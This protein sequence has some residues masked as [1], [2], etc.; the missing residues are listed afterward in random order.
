DKI[1]K[2]DADAIKDE[3]ER[4]QSTY[5][6]EL[7]NLKA[8]HIKELDA[9]ETY[10]QAMGILRQT[11]TEEELKDIKTL[12]DAR[13][14]I[15][16][17]QQ[18]KEAEL[19]MQHID[20]LI[21]LLNTFI[22]EGKM[23]N[24]SFLD[25]IISTEE[26]E[27]AKKILNELIE[28]LQQLKKERREATGDTSE[29][30][31]PG[32]KLRGSFRTDILGFTTEDWEILFSA[33]DKTGD[34]LEEL[35]DRV[36]M[37]AYAIANAWSQANQIAKNSEDKALAEYEKRIDYRKKLLDD[38]LEQG[39]ITQE[40]YNEKTQ[41]LDDKLDRQ[42][43]IIAR[44]QAI[45]DR[46]VAIFEAI[47]NT[48][49][50]MTKVLDKPW[51]MALVGLAGGLQLATITSTPLPE[52][53]GKDDGGFL[54]VMR[55]QDRKKFRA[56]HEPNRRGWI[57]R[58]TVITGEKPGSRE[59][60]IPDEA[61]D[62]PSIAPLIRLLEMAR[63]SHNLKTIDLTSAL[64]ALPGRATGGFILQAPAPGPA[65]PGKSIPSAGQNDLFVLHEVAAA[66]LNLNHI[67]SSGKIRTQLV[68]Q[69][70]RD[71]DEKV[72]TI[73]NESTI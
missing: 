26:W 70:L 22:D 17:D 4:R 37:A 18:K 30:K 52:I 42:K 29:K 13:L 44:R 38:Q 23:E 71:M 48:A 72:E 14:L 51:L 50:A 68:Y 63:I 27:A 59:Y 61:M 10:D 1:D 16:K 65:S 20:T 11:Y 67:L 2:L 43:A 35:A 64:P 46:N 41:A 31:D 56:R 21:T 47:I 55:A 57:T 7:A 58:P 32:L 9:V 62:N 24:V 12:N 36:G 40:I 5:D 15:Q 28:K 45:R 54:D 39:I 33:I 19:S 60:V 3:I 6:T 53:P 69:D 8:H 73:E 49:V 34:K 66:I 25:N